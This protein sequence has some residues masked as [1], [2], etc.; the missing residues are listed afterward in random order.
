MV[1]R[2]TKRE[3]LKIGAPATFVVL[4]RNPIEAIRNTTAAIAPLNADSE[5]YVVL[6]R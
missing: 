6:G 2:T 5:R 3:S 1:C 4:E